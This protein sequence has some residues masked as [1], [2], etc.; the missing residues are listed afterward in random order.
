[1]TDN[2]RLTQLRE[3]HSAATNGNHEGWDR[4]DTCFLLKVIDR[5]QA[6]LQALYEVANV[7]EDYV[8]HGL[9]PTIDGLLAAKI[10]AWKESK[11]DDELKPTHYC[12]E[13]EE[14]YDYRGCEEPVYC[15]WINCDNDDPLPRIGKGEAK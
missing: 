10:S 6:E 7:A 11:R 4:C 5:R 15:N 14:V 8:S 1:M 9:I 2:E 13:C 12:P 3:S